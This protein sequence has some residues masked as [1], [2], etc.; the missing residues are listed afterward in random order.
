MEPL[1]DNSQQIEY[2]NE[3]AG[4]RWVDLQARLDEQLR[5]LGEVALD[6]AALRPGQHVLDVGCGC[7]DSSLA[8]LRRVAPDGTVTG[9]DVSRPMLA[10]ARERAR[11][12]GASG[13]EFVEA[14]VQHHAFE[15]GRLDAVISRFGVM[16]FS[17][18][19]SAF[20][21]LRA[22]M[23]PGGR[24]CFVCWQPPDRNAWVTAPL[25][26]VAQHVALPPPP[27]PGAPGPFAFADPDR[28]R[29]ILAAAGFASVVV[30]G[31]TGEL[32]IGG[33]R[34]VDEAADF[35]IE[36]GPASRAMREAGADADPEV[37]ARVVAAAAEALAPFAGSDG[38][39]APYAAWLVTARAPR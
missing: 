20:A 7:G 37:R 39:R 21:N 38:V 36:I 22:S 34:D 5:P 25:A 14:D 35:L 30:D 9:A 3:Q 17:T 26:A 19:E 18:P 27:E 11:E 15:P 6:A 8:A 10:R 29:G 31:L 33:A 2:W 12:Q 28:V 4:P 1:T 16:F 13:L 23:A 32:S 24:L